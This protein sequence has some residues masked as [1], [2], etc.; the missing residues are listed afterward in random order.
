[1]SIYVRVF[2]RYFHCMFST[3][4][5]NSLF[6]RTLH[7]LLLQICSNPLFASQTQT[8]LHSSFRLQHGLYFS[9]CP[10]AILFRLRLHDSRSL[11]PWTYVL[12][13]PKRFSVANAIF[14][15]RDKQYCPGRLFQTLPGWKQNASAGFWKSLPEN[16]CW[17]CWMDALRAARSL[18]P[19]ALWCL[20]W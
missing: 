11:C 18:L 17:T 9:L 13:K 4:T 14:T 2:K 20:R 8:Q 12:A 19:L 15:L 1:M 7:Y 3:T 5:K 6:S 10:P 16:C